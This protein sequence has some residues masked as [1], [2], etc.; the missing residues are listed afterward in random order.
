MVMPTATS[1][2]TTHNT[3]GDDP[4]VDQNGVSV[5]V[6]APGLRIAC[7]FPGYENGDNPNPP[8]SPLPAPR[9]FRFDKNVDHNEGV[10]GFKVFYRA[11][12]D[13]RGCGD[14][15]VILHQGDAVEG[16]FVRFHTFQYAM[17]ICDSAGNMRII[18]VGGQ[19]DSGGVEDQLADDGNRPMKLMGTPDDFTQ[20]GYLFD[21]YYNFFDF[22]E[23]G[24]PYAAHI[25][26][27]F[28]NDGSGVST[29]WDAADPHHLQFVCHYING[30]DDY[31]CGHDGSQ[32]A[33]RDLQY[34]ILQPSQTTWCAS[35]DM[36]RAVNTVVSCGTPG[37][38]QQRVD[39]GV[40][41]VFEHEGVVH[42]N[43]VPGLQYPD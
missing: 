30:H 39:V 36:T 26:Q 32:H 7:G 31:S 22:E 37:S 9:P 21:I 28:A 6:W 20:R 16:R 13:P 27:G 38:W 17:A 25:N 10:F 35:F 8:G 14:V 5:D 43:R 18:D 1:T 15:R 23:P 19:T 24:A 2:A 40:G 42:D 3:C 33:L 41:P 11:S 4:A 34:E 12:G 29:F